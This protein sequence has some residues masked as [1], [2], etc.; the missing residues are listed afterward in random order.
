MLMFALLASGLICARFD[1]FPKIT[2]H[3]RAVG[4]EEPCG[5]VAGTRVIA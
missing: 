4:T 3:L 2:E 1:A 5:D